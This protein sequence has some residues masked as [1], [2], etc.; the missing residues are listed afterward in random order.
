MPHYKYKHIDNTHEPVV[1]HGFII[2][3][4]CADLW[5][6]ECGQIVESIDAGEGWETIIESDEVIISRRW[7]PSQRNSNG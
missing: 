6:A 1:A 4:D 7:T 3:P 2:G 5:C